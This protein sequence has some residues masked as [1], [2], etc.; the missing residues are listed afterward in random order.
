M[1][2]YL[3]CV[4]YLPKNFLCYWIMID[5]ETSSFGFTLF[6]VAKVSVDYLLSL[7]FKN[8]AHFNL[9]CTALML[10]K[11]S[12]NGESFQNIS[13]GKLHFIYICPLAHFLL[14]PAASFFVYKIIPVDS[15]LSQIVLSAR[16]P[17][18]DVKR[19]VLVCVSRLSPS[20]L[21]RKTIVLGHNT[22]NICAYSALGKIV[23]I[24]VI[25]FYVCI[26]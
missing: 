9:N 11:S 17:S 12:A 7:V 18:S 6:I 19:K 21:F 13:M 10:S 24:I 3:S 5:T 15:N 1:L 14:I 4:K 22:D 8:Y 16:T 2:S 25:H 23:P 26:K 20:V